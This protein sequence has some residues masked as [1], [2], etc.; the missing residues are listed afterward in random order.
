MLDASGSS[1]PLPDPSSWTVLVADE[2]SAT[3]M[4]LG[5]AVRAF[6]PEIRLLEA[7]TGRQALDLIT[8]GAPDLAFVNIQLPEMSGA[9]ALAWSV[10]QGAQVPT[11]LMS[12]H[13]LP[14][15]VEVSTELGAYEFLKKPF[16]PDHIL[17][18]MR[19]FARMRAPARLLLVDDS[20]TAR[21]LVRRVLAASQFSLE[22]DETDGGQHALK[23]LRLSP[24]DLAL[25]DF[26]LQGTIDGL[27]TAC[28][29]REAA[30]STKILLMSASDNASIAQSARHFGVTSFLR[31]PFY[32]HQV[33]HAL[34]TAFGLRRPYLLNARAAQPAARAQ[35]A[36]GA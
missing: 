4:T 36:G 18:L 27:E 10:A 1:R 17:H 2:S 6:D 28:Q 14:K 15:W 21:Q 19:G 31:K 20:A 32:A 22:I 30:P 33:D 23:L 9:E 29:A 34:H 25:I 13:V 5:A 26:N 8:K 7:Q 24:Y 35:R 3:R 11:V 16:D 12:A